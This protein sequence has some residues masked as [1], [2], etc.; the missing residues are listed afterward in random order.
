MDILLSNGNTIR[1]HCIASALQESLNPRSPQQFIQEVLAM[2]PVPIDI[3]ITVRL[4]ARAQYPQAAAYLQA[5]AAQAGWQVASVALLA[6]P[7]NH[8][9]PIPPAAN[10]ANV[11]NSQ[12]QPTNQ[13]ADAVRHAWG[14]V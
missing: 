8:R 13:S 7:A 6:V 12:N 11:P 14:W 9:L 5:F 1:V 10:I 2:N 4:N 3:T